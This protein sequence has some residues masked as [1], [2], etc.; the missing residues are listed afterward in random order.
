MKKILITGASGFIGRH[1]LPLL[2][3]KGHEIHAVGRRR[4]TETGFPGIV[5]HEADLLIPGT[6]AQL[7]RQ[8]RPDAVLHLAWCTEPG[9]FWEAKE[10]LEW[11]RA[12]LELLT[13][14]SDNGGKRIVAAGTCAEYVDSAGECVENSTPLLPATL[15]GVSKHAFER[16]LHFSSR[17]AGLSSAW[18]R[19]FFM[20]GPGEH[21]S[22]LVAHVVRSL[23]EGEPAHCSEGRQVLDF[24]YIEDVASAFVALLESEVQ[25]PV[26]IASGLPVSVRE[27]LQE[28][29]RQ[30]GRSE[31][32]RFGALTTGSEAE[33][34]WANTKRLEKEVG[35]VPRYN[36]ASGIKQTIEWW[37]HS[38][39]LFASG[40]V[41]QVGR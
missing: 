23:L 22:R 4:P 13:A 26:N 3:P 9:K 10:N 39:E 11:V 18:G 30:L 16:I 27:V 21:P 7:I 28:I 24:M 38:S 2:V 25:G 1:C 5:W 36:L 15:Y 41:P 31:L 20:Y 29:G 12:S 6:P 35:W 40:S 19:V 37:R 34:L 33:R 32:I 8:V 14:F 17:P